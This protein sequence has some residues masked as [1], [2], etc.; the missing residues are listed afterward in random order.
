[1]SIRPRS[2]CARATSADTAATRAYLDEWIYGVPDR[3]VYVEKMGPGRLN[4]L[5]PPPAY[6]E[7]VNLGRYV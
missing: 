7:P 6:S 4:A 1:M 2:L 3:A 5:V